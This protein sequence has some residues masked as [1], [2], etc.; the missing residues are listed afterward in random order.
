MRH[1]R[2]LAAVPALALLVAVAFGAGAAAQGPFPNLTV[3]SFAGPACA[4][5]GAVIGGQITI[6]ETNTGP[7]NLPAAPIGT[8]CSG[9]TENTCSAIG[10][11]ISADAT[12]T[13]SDILLTGGREN[14]FSELGA[15]VPFNVS[16][17]ITDFLFA[18]AS[19]ASGS[20]TGNVFLGA[21]V[22][23]GGTVTES[24]ETDNTASV[25]IQIVAAGAGGCGQEDLVI[26]SFTHDPANPTTAD[27]ITLKAV[28]ENAGGTAAG[29]S[30]ACIDVGGEIC[31]NPNSEMLFAVPALAAGASYDVVRSIDL[32]VAQGYINNAV[33]DVD[34]DVAESNEGNNTASDNFVVTEAVPVTLVYQ[35]VSLPADGTLLG[36]SGCSLTTPCNLTDFRVTYDPDPGFLGTDSFEYQIYDPRTGLISLNPAIVDILVANPPGFGVNLTVDFQGSGIG[37]VALDVGGSVVAICT[38]DCTESFGPGDIVKLQARP[39]DLSTFGSWGG[40]C[41]IAGSSQIATI[42]LPSS[43]GSTC[44]ATFNP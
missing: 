44:T 37:E 2:N 43:G 4:E 17:T 35:V 9:Q 39:L 30:T 26:S 23:E 22:D 16:D 41:S 40:A 27:G 15:G 33:A 5:I 36:L 38:A 32:D 28:V 20:P 24:S 3:T 19:V 8:N 10:F 21:I 7:A 1:T 42:T 31:S 12:I 13:T 25:P 29:P 18:G 14:L 11:Y 6:T 34:D